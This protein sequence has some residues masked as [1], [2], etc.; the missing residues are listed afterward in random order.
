M[1]EP[2]SLVLQ[3]PLSQAAS[4]QP[5][6]RPG[7]LR[8]LWVE[9]RPAQWVKNGF[10]FA[11]L[12][13]S[14]HAFSLDTLLRSLAAFGCFCA[15]SSSVYLLNDLV[16]CAQDRLHPE[17]RHRPLAAGLLNVWIARIAAAGL[18][19]PALSGGMALNRSFA[20]VLAAY[21][22]LNVLYAWRLKHVVILDVFAVAAG[23]LLRVMAGAVVI[24]VVMS[25]WL[26]I[27][28]TGLSLFI[29]LC[30]RRHEQVLL[31]EG[32]ANHRHVLTDYPIPF[33]DAMIGVLTA[34]ASST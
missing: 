8:A 33:L 28:T 31:A 23:Y 13:F 9:L 29:A 5:L 1:I 16:D 17:K 22:A 14:P 19:V 18:L 12:F 15:V 30:K 32:A 25:A 26:L 3:E 11:P 24:Q 7:W 2:D 20:M 34:S 6:A 27:C 4:S 10:V 21:W